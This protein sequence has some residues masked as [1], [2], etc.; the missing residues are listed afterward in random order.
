[1]YVFFRT[2]ALEVYGKSL[3]KLGKITAVKNETG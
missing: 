3:Q 2:S 1:M